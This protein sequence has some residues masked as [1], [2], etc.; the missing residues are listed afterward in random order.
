MTDLANAEEPLEGDVEVEQPGEELAESVERREELGEG[1]ACKD[2]GGQHL[3]QDSDDDDRRR[4]GEVC[5]GEKGDEVFGGGELFAGLETGIRHE[6]EGVGDAGDDTV[7]ENDKIDR[8]EDGQRRFG[9]ELLY[10]SLTL[11]LCRVEHF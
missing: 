3:L 1:A 11:V 9:A 5:Q 10:L 2:R 8:L 4:K 7:D 6:Y